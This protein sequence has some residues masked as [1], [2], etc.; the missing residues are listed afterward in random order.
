MLR[1]TIIT[2]SGAPESDLKWE[3]ELTLAATYL[4]EGRPFAWYLDLG[5]SH[6]LDL[7]ANT[8]NLSSYQVA[9]D[10][11]TSR[12]YPKFPADIYLYRGVPSF[13]PRERGE[14]ELEERFAESGIKEW[15]VYLMDAFADF[16]QRVASFLPLESPLFVEI[17]GRPAPSLALSAQ[18]VSPARFGHLGVLCPDLPFTLRGVDTSEG[19]SPLALCLPLDSALTGVVL[20]QIEHVLEVAANRGEMISIAPES[21]LH[22]V[23]QGIDQLIVLPDW[24]SIQGK[25]RVDGF[26]AAG[27]EILS[28]KEFFQS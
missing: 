9:A 20:E 21:L 28:P 16:L 24:L 2:L 7:T 13:L 6:P 17:K 10:E 5:L 25:R 23:W 15:S 4:E 18:I 26:I 14:E 1:P 12:V 3:K 22:Q 27:G 11:F 8:R 19:Q